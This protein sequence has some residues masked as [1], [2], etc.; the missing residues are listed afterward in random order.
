MRSD[1][2]VVSAIVARRLQPRLGGRSVVSAIL[3]LSA[4]A[5][6]STPPV[7]SAAPAVEARPARDLP[8]API[9]EPYVG[10]LCT[11]EPTPQAPPRYPAI[12]F[13]GGYG[14]DGEA[15]RLALEFAQRGYVTAAVSYFG[16]P[17]TPR[18]LVD[19]PLE[20]G[21]R[22][23]AALA[24]RVDVDPERL[25]V[26]GSSKGGEY[27]LLVAA[28][29]PAVKAVIANVPSPF[30][31]YG[32]G[33]GGAPDGCSWSRAGRPLPCV[34]LAP[35]SDASWRSRD[36]RRPIAFRAHYEAARDNS[37][38]VARAFFPLERIAGPVLCLAAGD[39]QVWNSEAQCAL[40]MDYLRA[41][42]HPFSDR[43]RTLE[44]AGHVYLNARSGPEAAMSTAPMGRGGQMAFG[45]SP[46]ADARAA[47][48]A[49]AAIA[50]LVPR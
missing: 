4:C 45:G 23:V 32:L 13:F 24:A 41:H 36:E 6:G 47:R 22:A 25:A 28:S 43:A 3:V 42:H 48:E 46:E 44:G 18:T 21:V 20:I 33:V 19:V 27:A 7:T 16:A 50:A 5:V 49:L 9:D 34:P 35:G 37:A 31:W 17:G 26:M 38:A 29:T 10:T 12:V 1:A 15:R 11:P 30:A 14:G 2:A 40:A 39:D 8:C